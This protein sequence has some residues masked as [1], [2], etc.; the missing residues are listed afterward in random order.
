MKKLFIC[1]LFFTS[2]LLLVKCDSNPSDSGS[3][4]SVSGMVFD[5]ISKDLN[6]HG[7]KIIGDF[8]NSLK[9][10]FDESVN[11]VFP[12]IQVEGHTDSR[13]ITGIAFTNWEL[14][15]ARAV[16][17][18]R[19]IQDA[20]INPEGKECKEKDCKRLLSAR[21]F[22]KYDYIEYDRDKNNRYI[23]KIGKENRRIDII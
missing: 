10:L 13:P 4:Y 19:K 5:V 16:T 2:I 8:T 18:I 15:N 3:F 9:M 1:T 17:I 11:S 12:E 6:T 14:S 22:S 21:G 20:G 7:E 23:E